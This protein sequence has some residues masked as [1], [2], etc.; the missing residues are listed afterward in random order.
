MKQIRIKIKP[1]GE[2]E[3]ETHGMKGKTCLK[4]IE[5]VERLTNAVTD[6]SDFTKEY[7]ELEENDIINTEQEAAL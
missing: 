5:Q 3:A 2:I 7:L 6:D 4:Y 1:N